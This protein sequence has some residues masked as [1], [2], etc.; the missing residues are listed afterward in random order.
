MNENYIYIYIYIYIMFKNNNLKT[1]VKLIDNQQK[2]GNFTQLNV[3]N[4]GNIGG[5]LNVGGTLTIKDAPINTSSGG[6]TNNELFNIIN[7]LLSVSNIEINRFNKLGQDIDGKTN[8][9]QSGYSICMNDA[10][11]RII[12]GTPYKYINSLRNCG[13]VIIW[14]YNT[15]LNLWTIVDVEIVG[16]NED[17]LF[18]LSVCMNG[19]GDKIGIGSKTNVK[20]YEYKN[21]KWDLLGLPLS[22]NYSDKLYYYGFYA[23]MNNSG[24]RIIIATHYSIYANDNNDNVQVYEYN[25]L[26]GW[27]P[28]GNIISR[29]NSNDLLGFSID[30]NYDGTIIA[31]GSPGTTPYNSDPGK[32]EI[33][34]Y[35]SINNSWDL[36]ISLSAVKSLYTDDYGCLVCMSDDGYR[37]A[38]SNTDGMR[39][40]IV[41]IYN[42]T[43]VYTQIGQDIYREHEW[44]NF[45]CSI[46]LNSNGNRIAIGATYN[47]LHRGYVKIYDYDILNNIWNHVGNDIIGE[48]SYDNSGYSVRLNSKGDR[49]AIGAIYNNT[50]NSIYYSGHVRVYELTNKK[51]AKEIIDNA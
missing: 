27:L 42:I 28:F 2:T 12:I 41:R 16:T 15:I 3:K 32:V 45:G 4:N 14:D 13:S 44:D 24:N 43:D 10:G 26:N 40:G 48:G 1:L 47:G 51:I 22:L 31:I 39:N 38:V 50:S 36:S 29:N 46:S 17:E 35:Q 18:G 21:G 23:S 33:Y 49:V 30:I 20:I 5:T 9:E 7:E 37:I 25:V 34:K 6:I 19:I 11:D 8:N